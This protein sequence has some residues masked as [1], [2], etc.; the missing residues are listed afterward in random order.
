M[1]VEALK[2]GKASLHYG[3][4]FEADVVARHLS[5]DKPL[6]KS[7]VNKDVLDISRSL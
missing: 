1:E 7:Y 2:I 5:K 6:A 3:S 4:G